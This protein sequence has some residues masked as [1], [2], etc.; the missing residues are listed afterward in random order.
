MRIA[1]KAQADHRRLTGWSLVR[2]RP[3]EPNKIKD[4]AAIG[5][6]DEAAKEPAGQHQDNKNAAARPAGGIAKTNRSVLIR[7]QLAGALRRRGTIRFDLGVD[8]GGG[9]PELDQTGNCLCS[10]GRSTVMRRV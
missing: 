8:V 9:K 4:L 1:A 7:L 2:I 5:K 6:S 3:G 10:R